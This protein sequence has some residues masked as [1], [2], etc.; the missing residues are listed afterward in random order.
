MNTLPYFSQSNHCNQSSE[1]MLVV[2]HY[3]LRLSFKC[4]SL[5]GMTFIATSNSFQG[6]STNL[7]WIIQSLHWCVENRNIGTPKTLQWWFKHQCFNYIFNQYHETERILKFRFPRNILTLKYFKIN[8]VI[9]TM[10]ANIHSIFGT[11]KVIHIEKV[12]TIS[13]YSLIRLYE[14]S[15][16]YS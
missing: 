1:V 8:K 9:T 2:E 15:F 14:Y 11:D 3:C 6:Q 16:W 5:A 10:K 12:K 7:F 4:N 13:F